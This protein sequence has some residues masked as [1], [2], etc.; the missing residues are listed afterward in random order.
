MNAKYLPGAAIG[1]KIDWADEAPLYHSKIMWILCP[2]DHQP[3]HPPLNDVDDDDNNNSRH[4]SLGM[5]MS[6]WPRRLLSG[7]KLLFCDPD[8]V[9][10]QVDRWIWSLWPT[11][12]NQNARSGA[13]ATCVECS[14]IG[15]GKLYYESLS[16]SSG[17]GTECVHDIFKGNKT[18]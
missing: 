2:S 14:S 7:I 5:H 9:I 17:I 8:Y 13:T 1:W 18:I 3:H 10:R 15:V 4:R 12:C 16:E 6:D 11:H